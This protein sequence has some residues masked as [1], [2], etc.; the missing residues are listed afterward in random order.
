LLAADTLARIAR[1]L[2]IDA[3]VAI[4]VFVGIAHFAGITEDTARLGGEAD[5]AIRA[6][7][8]I[9][10]RLAHGALARI[11]RGLAN[12][13][14][15]AGRALRAE[16]LFARVAGFAG[17]AGHFSSSLRCIA[18]LANVAILTSVAELAG[19]A[20]SRIAQLAH[21]AK[22]AADA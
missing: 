12:V 20:F 2:A 11:A 21:D 15:L 14:L 19:R 13:A 17:R 4:G 1:C 6:L 16:A 3:H 9:A 8:R 5:F 18:E 10:G 22:V 7:A